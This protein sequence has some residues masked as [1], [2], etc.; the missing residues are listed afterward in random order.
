MNNGQWQISTEHAGLQLAHWLASMRRLGSNL[1]ALDSLARGR[2]YVNGVVQTPADA[3]RV[4]REGDLVRVWMDRQ[5]VHLMEFIPLEYDRLEI[6]Y[7]DDDLIVLNKPAGMLSTPHPFVLEEASLF[8][9]VEEYLNAEELQPFI[10]HRIDRDTS[11]LVLFAKSLEAQQGLRE[12][13]ERREPERVYRAVTQGIPEPDSGMWQD[14]IAWNKKLHRLAPAPEADLFIRDA[15]CHYRV[16]EPFSDA[17]LIEVRLVTGRR[18]QIRL[19]AQMHGHP[20]AGEQTFIGESESKIEFGRQA[21]HAHRLGFFQPRT[22]R[23]LMLEAPL[24][25][26]FTSLLERLRQP[27]SACLS[28]SETKLTMPGPPI[29]SGGKTMQATMQLALDPEKNYEIVNGVPVEKEM[30]GARHGMIAMRLAIRLGSFIEA[31]HLGETFTE[32]NYKIGRN[33]RIPDLSFV[34]A[35]RIPAEGVPEGV[36]QIPPD[37]AVEII[38][39]NDLH[40]KVNGKVLEYLEAGVQQVWIVSPEI[41]TVTIFRSMEQ[42]QVFAKDSVLESPDLLPGFHCPLTELFST[43]VPA[44]P[45]ASERAS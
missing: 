11:G 30:P 35:D 42:V 45:D 44:S 28:P 6:V 23:R 20:L 40:E 24:P 12:Q 34:A 22:G 33:E 10:V 19:Q 29:S 8:D 2:I 36:W 13:F 39:P 43:A 31:S 15:I 14:V 3:E 5:D 4:L 38:S 32:V 7:E 37:L 21:L 41:R 17:A 9:L 27:M 18:N 1:R 26:D 25:E 16:L